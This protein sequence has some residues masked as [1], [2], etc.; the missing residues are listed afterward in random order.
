MPP[1]NQTLGKG[2]Y[3]PVSRWN[4]YIHLTFLDNSRVVQEDKE[5]GP[6]FL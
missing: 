1:E 4:H 5:G 6:F 2:L 3:L